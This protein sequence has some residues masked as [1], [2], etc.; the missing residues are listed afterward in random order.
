MLSITIDNTLTDML[1][2]KSP[3]I[4]TNIKQ[5]SNITSL[6]PID[7][8]KYVLPSANYFNNMPKVWYCPWYY[9][10]KQQFCNNKECSCLQNAL[11]YYK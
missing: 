5:I 6:Q 10:Y 2:R 9:F 7:K 1:I 11:T 4:A 8:I 3:V